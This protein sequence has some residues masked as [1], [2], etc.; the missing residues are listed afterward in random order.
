MQN[1]IEIYSLTYVKSTV[2]TEKNFTYQHIKKHLKAHR[3]KGW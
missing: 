1:E 2:F 3:I